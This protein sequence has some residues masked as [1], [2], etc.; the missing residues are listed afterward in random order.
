[1]S[2]YVEL[3]RLYASLDEWQKCEHTTKLDVIRQCRVYV[4]KLVSYLLATPHVGSAFCV[5]SDT[6]RIDTLQSNL[7]ENVVVFASDS[8]VPSE[9]AHTQRQQPQTPVPRVP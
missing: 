4:A 2:F 3:E 5:P 8:P 6:L 1:M 9:C 7:Q